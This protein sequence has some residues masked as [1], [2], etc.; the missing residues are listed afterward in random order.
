MSLYSPGRRANGTNPRAH[1]R[2][3][4]AVRAWKRKRRELG[5]KRPEPLMTMQQM[6]ARDT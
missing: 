3:K 1:Y 5:I 6:K 2:D 4:R